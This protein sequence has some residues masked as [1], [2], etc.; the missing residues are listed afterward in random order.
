M[1]KKTVNQKNGGFRLAYAVLWTVLLLAVFSA[2][3]TIL[4]EKGSIHV[5]SLNVTAKGILF[6]STL[7]GMMLS[8]ER[9]SNAAFMLLG[10]AELVLL[11]FFLSIVVIDRE[12]SSFAMPLIV[13]S[14]ILLAFLLKKGKKKTRPAQRRRS[15]N[16]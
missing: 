7:L 2:I 15:K 1:G 8:F 14:A 3:V 10:G 6:L 4:I 12:Q 16:R 5:D 9:N 13:F 11:L